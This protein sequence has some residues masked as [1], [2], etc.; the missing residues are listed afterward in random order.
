MR[1][2]TKVRMYTQDPLSSRQIALD[3]NSLGPFRESQSL[4]FSRVNDN[5][6]HKR[7]QQIFFLYTLSQMTD[8]SVTFS[9]KL[10]YF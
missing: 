3:M 1:V 6:G 9:K 10:T 8:V 7:K 2:V 4:H 5:T